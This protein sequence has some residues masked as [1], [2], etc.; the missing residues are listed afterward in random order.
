MKKNI[1]KRLVLSL[2]YYEKKHEENRFFDAWWQF[3]YTLSYIVLG[4]LFIVTNIFLG[5]LNLEIN[6]F[7]YIG[8]TIV[9]LIVN[10]IFNDFRNTPFQ[11]YVLKEYENIEPIDRWLLWLI[12]L[13][14]I[15]LFIWSMDLNNKMLS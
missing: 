11:D 1:I 6:F 14:L 9:L 12:S 5:V 3:Y 13:V 7:I 10:H 8:I 2:Y 4:F 15:L